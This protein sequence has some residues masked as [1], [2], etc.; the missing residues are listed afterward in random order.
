MDIMP[1]DKGHVLVIPK[2]EAV[3]MS[4]LP[5]EYATAVFATAKK[6]I[7]AQRTVFNTQGIVQM[8]LNHAQSGQ[9]VFHYH[10]HLVPTHLS[11]IGNHESTMGNHDELSEL[12]KKLRDVIV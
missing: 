1:V 11:K 4:D 6:V 8:Q 12:A 3:E 9:S 7:Q 10:M 5:L 2:C